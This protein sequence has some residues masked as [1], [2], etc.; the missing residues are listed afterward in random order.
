VCKEETD[1]FQCLLLEDRQVNRRS[2]NSR[3]RTELRHNLREQFLIHRELER[4]TEACKEQALVV[5]KII[6]NDFQSMDDSGYFD[7]DADFDQEV[8][9]H[10]DLY[11]EKTRNFGRLSDLI[12][13]AEV[14]FKKIYPDGIEF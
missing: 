3:W 1:S 5:K 6:A 11:K 8:K 9:K 2:M 7:D 4:L 13:R 14:L 10:Q 12:S